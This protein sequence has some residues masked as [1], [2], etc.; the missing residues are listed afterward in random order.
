MA[1]GRGRSVTVPR[2]TAGEEGSRLW[3]ARGGALFLGVF[4]PSTIGALA[5]AL[6]IGALQTI[7]DGH[8]DGAAVSIFLVLLALVAVWLSW[9]VFRTAWDVEID[10]HGSLRLFATGTYW[11]VAPGEIIAVRGDAYG[12]LLTLITNDRRICLWARLDDRR[13]LLTAIFT[14]NPNVVMDRQVAP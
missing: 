8:D 12:L 4:L 7:T 9:R 14:A 10:P 1:R 3:R 2:A 6:L 5:V 11:A 13:G